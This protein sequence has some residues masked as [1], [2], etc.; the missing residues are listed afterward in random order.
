MRSFLTATFILV[1]IVVMIVCNSVAVIKDI[2]AML[3]ICEEISEETSP[4]AE[5][6]LYEKW[7]DCQDFLSLSIHH[8][9]IE[10]AEFAILTVCRYESDT[11]TRDVQL[12]T[13]INTLKHIADSQRFAFNS[14]F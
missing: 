5:D 6:R 4:E 3:A 10:R 14:I 8:N 7:Q 9:E 1:G 13:L 12:E 11:E 2:N